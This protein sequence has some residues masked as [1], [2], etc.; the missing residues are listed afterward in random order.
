MKYEKN[1]NLVN[2]RFVAKISDIRYLS[3]NIMLKYHK[4]QHWYQ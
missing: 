4:W 1:N 2:I 3:E